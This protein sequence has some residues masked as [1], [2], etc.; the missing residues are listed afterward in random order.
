[1]DEQ[2]KWNKIIEFLRCEVRIE[3]EQVLS[4][5]ARTHISEPTHK[6]SNIDT[7]SRKSYVSTNDSGQNPVICFICGK[8]DHVVSFTQRGLRLVNYISCERF[9]KM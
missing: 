9:V 7:H 4:E 2:G 6:S 1:M 3:E 5:K 8:D